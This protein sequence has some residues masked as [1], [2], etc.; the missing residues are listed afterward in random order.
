MP[1]E[2]CRKSWVEAELMYKCKLHLKV[3]HLFDVNWR[4]ILKWT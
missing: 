4:I 3:R 1:N 2:I